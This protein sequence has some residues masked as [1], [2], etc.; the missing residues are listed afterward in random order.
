[1]KRLLT[2]F[3][4]VIFPAAAV[5]AA[6]PGAPELKAVADASGLLKVSVTVTAPAADVD[7]KPLTA[8]RKMELRRDGELVKVFESVNPGEEYQF[9]DTSV[10]NGYAEYTAVA[11]G[12]DGEGEKSE[13][14][15]VFAGVDIP[16]PPKQLK[17]NV[18]SGRISF[19]WP[20]SDKKGENGE[21]VIQSRVSYLLE[22]LDDSYNLVS[23]LTD[24]K[25][26]AHDYFIDTESGGQD[27]RRF[28]IRAYN[29]AGYSGYV[30]SRVVVGAPYYF[31]LKESFAGG[32]HHGLAWQEGDGSFVID[33]A[34]SSD[35]DFG[36]L[37]CVPA[38]D[39]S[40]SSFNMG[41]ISMANTLNPRLSFRLASLGED[42]SMNVRIARADG[43]EASLLTIK[44]P[45]DDWTLFTVDLSPLKREKYIIPKFQLG[46]DNI[47]IVYIDDVRFEDP[48]P[49]DLGVRVKAPSSA[50]GATPVGVE[51]TNEGLEPADLADID[52]YADGKRVTTL[53]LEETLHPGEVKVFDTEV[54]VTGDTSVEVKAVVRWALDVNPMN[55]TA[56][57]QI[58]P[59]PESQGTAGVDC[60][61]TTPAAETFPQIFLPDGRM[62]PGVSVE[63][64]SPGLYIIDGKK[65]LIK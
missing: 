22:A 24:T 27:I 36:S 62:L 45:V 40:V 14:Q 42:E 33:T 49:S 41:K 20:K 12:A 57:A 21:R 30:Y 16:L 32:V 53:K 38:M 65:V 26:Q 34:N 18:S 17:A 7:S 23:V 54:N 9:D 64:L 52:I 55:D 5:V 63:S 56:G 11:F 29:A 60:V 51:L 19:T 25:S 35:D 58:I 59:A 3:V 15:T 28:G 2:N 8:I 6:V 48:Y 13:V 37:A 61:E 50:F 31:P 4:S 43:A 47:N 39:G 1:M 10:T 46:A 44:G